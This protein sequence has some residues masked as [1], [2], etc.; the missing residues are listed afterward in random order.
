MI[1]YMLKFESQEQAE[2]VLLG[3]G[4]LRTT[5]IDDTTVIV[6]GIGQNID[7]IGTISKPDGTFTEVQGMRIPNMIPLDGYHVNVRAAG[8]ID[9]LQQYE[10][11]PTTPVRVWA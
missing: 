4:L 5:D 10:V 9:G 6:P 1:D 7:V 3:L 2:Q 8:A 11:F